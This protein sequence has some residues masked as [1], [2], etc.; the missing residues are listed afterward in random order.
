MQTLIP[1]EALLKLLRSE[2]ADMRMQAAAQAADIASLAAARDQSAAR[3]GQLAAALAGEEE[4]H[5]QTRADLA[6]AQGQVR[7][8]WPR[9]TCNLHLHTLQEDHVLL[10]VVSFQAAQCPCYIAYMLL[11]HEAGPQPSRLC[12]PCDPVEHPEAAAQ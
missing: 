4:A 7:R 9:S 3:S 12:K 11:L 6:A 10:I 1:S 5:T 8:A 2:V